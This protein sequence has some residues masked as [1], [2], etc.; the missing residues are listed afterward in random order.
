MNRILKQCLSESAK[1]VS[2]G[3]ATIKP[4]INDI[5][6]ARAQ[7]LSGKSSGAFDDVVTEMLKAL[8]PPFVY[9]IAWHFAKRITLPALS[10][11]LQ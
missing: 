4:S 6:D 2:S 7:M 5:I 8:S 3:E 10:K 11:K 9:V 1:R